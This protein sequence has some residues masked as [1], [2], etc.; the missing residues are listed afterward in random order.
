M[1]E[2]ERVRLEEERV[3][4]LMTAREIFKAGFKRGLSKAGLTEDAD[5]AFDDWLRARCR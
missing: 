5:G 3:E 2:Q 4:R 1:T